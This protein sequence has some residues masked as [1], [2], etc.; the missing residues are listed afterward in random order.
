MTTA[1]MFFLALG[2][3]LAAFVGATALRWL[4]TRAEAAR[5]WRERAEADLRPQLEAAGRPASLRAYQRAYGPRGQLYALAGLAAAA[6]VSAPA[7]TALHG[8]WRLGWLASGRPEGF[9]PGLLLY[10]FYLFF[11]LILCWVGVGALCARLFHARR[12]AGFAA[13]LAQRAEAETGDVGDGIPAHDGAS[14]KS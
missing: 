14:L 2:V 8:V 6:L 7:L 5:L 12:P 10:Q 3:T 9:A 1:Q 4:Q 13:E 11:G